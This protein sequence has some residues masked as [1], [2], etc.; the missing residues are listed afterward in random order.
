[1]FSTLRELRPIREL[2]RV[3]GERVILLSYVADGV[4]T[5]QRATTNSR[6]VQVIAIAVIV[7]ALTVT[8]VLLC[9]DDPETRQID[10]PESAAPYICLNDGY[11]F[12]L[13]PAGFERIGKT[14][15]A[16]SSLDGRRAAGLMLR[17]PKCGQFK[18]VG[19]VRCPKHGTVVPVW[20]PDGRPPKC[21]K[22]GTPRE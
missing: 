22:C 1:M 17:C 4:A 7:L 9:G 2:A 11:V 14:S 15:G 10:T 8:G 12:D 3:C 20:S 5:L 19:G 18:V 13:T 6:R 21:P 16:N